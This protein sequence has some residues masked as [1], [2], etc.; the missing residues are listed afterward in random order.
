MSKVFTVDEAIAFIKKE[1]E[2]SHT[3][4]DTTGYTSVEGIKAQIENLK[5]PTGR[6]F[7]AVRET[8]S[9]V[10]IMA[11]PIIKDSVANFG[12][13]DRQEWL[14]KNPDASEFH[15]LFDHFMVESVAIVGGTAIVAYSRGISNRSELE[16]LL[17]KHKD[18][19]ETCY[20]YQILHSNV[21]PS[22]ASKPN[23]VCY[24]RY[25]VLT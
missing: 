13:V 17:K 10:R 11:L 7:Y 5:A 12:I 1:W 20:L 21:V 23:S 9:S 14:E 15:H 3:K 6:V 18:A 24:V 16:E 2:R 25:A 22:F 4:D 8:D 19:G